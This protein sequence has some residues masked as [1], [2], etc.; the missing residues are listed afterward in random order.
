MLK[1][2]SKL[3]Y[4]IVVILLYCLLIPQ[5]I[6]AQIIVDVWTNKGGIGQGNLDGGRYVIGEYIQICFSVNANVDRL[7]FHII[8]PDGIDHVYYD[9]SIAAGTYCTPPMVEVGPPGVQRVIVEA[10]IG[11]VQVAYDEVDYNVIGCPAHGLH[12]GLELSIKWVIFNGES[13][14][15]VTI[16]GWIRPLGID[17]DTFKSQ[18]YHGYPGSDYYHITYIR[19]TLVKPSLEAGSLREIGR[20]LD[21]SSQRVWTRFEAR[22]SD[23]KLSDNELKIL[24]IR[25]SIKPRGFID[26]VTVKSFREIWRALPTPTNMYKDTALWWNT[27]ST[28]PDIYEIYLYPIATIYVKVESL[29]PG[30]KV[31]ILIDGVKM[32]TLSDASAS[33]EKRLIGLEHEV[34]LSPRVF[35][36]EPQSV[37]YTCINCPLHVKADEA[38]GLANVLL[39]FVKEYKVKLDTMPR[40]I[41]LIVDGKLIPSANLPFEEWWREGSEH[42]IS[43]EKDFL[44]TSETPTEREVY[45]FEKWSDGVLD[46]SRLIKTNEPYT[47][48]AILSR[49]KQYRVEVATE[50]G[51]ASVI[52]DTVK[53]ASVWCNEGS[54]VSAE[55]SS[56]QINLKS[57]VRAVFSH[58]TANGFSV[59][60]PLK[61]SS[62]IS[63][64]AI[65][66]TQ[67]FVNVDGVVASTSG[68]GWY[69]EGEEARISISKE[70]VYESDLKRYVF[71]EWVGDCHLVNCK[72]REFVVKVFQP[73]NFKATWYTQ[74]LLR[75][76]DNIPEINPK[77]DSNCHEWVNDGDVCVFDVAAE[78][79][80]TN[81]VKYRFAGW[82]W[83]SSSSLNKPLENRINKPMVIIVNYDPWYFISLEGGFAKPIVYGCEP[84]SNGAWCRNGSE[85]TVEMPTKSMGF[86]IVNEFD[87]WSLNGESFT[88]AGAVSMRIDRPLTLTAIWR[89]NYTGLIV[90]VASVCS[91]IFVI[92]FVNIRGQ[93]VYKRILFTLMKK[94]DIKRKLA[95]L[96]KLRREG[97]ISEEA[98]EEIKKEIER[99]S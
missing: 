49:S 54:Y 70:I 38:T 94:R 45:T 58:W 73:L 33:L 67:F 71:K 64:R 53:G 25:D 39:S 90:L 12:I 97:K 59:A 8:T 80:Y 86:L 47:I 35:T 82:L 42:S 32:G 83:D 99:E 36:E 48:S 76:E 10:W 34:D 23:L 21:D 1:L 52:C 88:S 26:E 79:N 17:W 98:Y 41:G 92:G 56:P 63:V 65:W 93:T 95:E 96:E 60:W 68:S 77:I 2:S 62:P 28:A 75:L 69:Y 66:R 37:R 24:R 18:C 11:G 27:E 22:F 78:I 84:T 81:N 50:Y 43:L 85:I 57:G 51:S 40:L 6:E 7:R 44:I 20:G 72:M 29:P 91:C 3:V 30:R 13:E 16:E 46:R 89:T 74:F 61:V 87:G 4:V 19:D 55:I 15:L 31:D 5:S 14:L 9:G